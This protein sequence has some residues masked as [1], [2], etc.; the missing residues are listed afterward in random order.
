[1]TNFTRREVLYEDKISQMKS[2]GGVTFLDASQLFVIKRISDI[3]RFETA[4]TEQRNSWGYSIMKCF[5]LECQ[6]GIL[7]NLLKKKQ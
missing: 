5:F 6:T 3:A 2:W 7:K 4:V 1:M